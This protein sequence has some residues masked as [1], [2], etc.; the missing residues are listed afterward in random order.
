MSLRRL[1]ASSLLLGGILFPFA[2]IA[3]D[4]PKAELHIELN[5]AQD[6]GNAC[7]LTFVAQN[8]VGQDIEQ[9]IFET[10]IFD[11]SGSVLLLSLFDFRELPADTP[12]VRQFDVPGT[13]CD[14]LGQVLVNGAHT[15]SVS[16][17]ESDACSAALRVSSRI[18]VELLG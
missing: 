12:R 11:A 16:D 6:T 17:T 8:G 9:A 18:G 4:A 7:R 2:A 13:A 15:C 14:S 5:T 10:V 3:D 1:A